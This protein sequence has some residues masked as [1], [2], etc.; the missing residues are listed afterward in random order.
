MHF[1]KTE[2]VTLG[3]GQVVLHYSLHALIAD[4]EKYNNIIPFSSRQGLVVKVVYSYVHRSVKSIFIPEFSTS[5]YRI[6]VRSGSQG[7][8]EE[9]TKNTQSKPN[10]LLTFN[11]KEGFFS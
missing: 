6:G 1:R 9:Q 7:F 3:E 4:F 10:N 2:A 8:L 11:V 5:L